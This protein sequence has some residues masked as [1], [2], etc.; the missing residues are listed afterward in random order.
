VL[1]AAA[2]G[3]WR[4]P[5]RQ[6]GHDDPR[7]RVPAGGTLDLIA[8]GGGFLAVQGDALQVLDATGAPT[9]P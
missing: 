4:T 3:I 9:S 7:V 8:F 6:G 5:G 1:A 2:I